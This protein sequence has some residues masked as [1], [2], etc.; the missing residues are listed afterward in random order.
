M[1]LFWQRPP[2]GAWS[3]D[4]IDGQVYEICHLRRDLVQALGQT[5]LDLDI[6]AFQIPELLE[7]FDESVK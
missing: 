3:Y 5:E 7:T 6:F 2:D 1:L 4:N